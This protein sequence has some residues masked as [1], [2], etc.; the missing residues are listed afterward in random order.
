MM[1]CGRRGWGRIITSH[2]ALEGTSCGGGQWC[3][4]GRCMKVNINESPPPVAPAPALPQVINGVW[5]SWSAVNC[6]Y[7]Q[8]APFGDGIGVQASKRTCTNPAPVNG[9]QDCAG[10]STRGII[11]AS[12]CQQGTETI[13]QYM[14]RI[15]T[16][17][18]T[19]RQDFELNG[20]GSQLK[21]GTESDRACKVNIQ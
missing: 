18:Q 7:C 1:W 20:K 13:Q 12:E 14:D 10:E 2:P 5:A 11:C 6:P 19:S 3:I 15:C 17:H 8:C 4:R 16:N 9:G 21:G